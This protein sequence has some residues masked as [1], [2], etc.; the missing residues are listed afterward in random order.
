MDWWARR[1]FDV[2]LAAKAYLRKSRK[3]KRPFVPIQL[4]YEHWAVYCK[5]VKQSNIQPEKPYKQIFHTHTT[6][7]WNSHHCIPVPSQSN[8]HREANRLARKKLT[9][10]KRWFVA[11]FCTSCIGVGRTLK[12][13]KFQNYAK[14]PC[15]GHEEERSNHI[16]L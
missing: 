10:A 8:I 2:D 5:Q 7:Y 11:K 15:C 12:Y 13:R 9:L 14:C 1:N 3:E 6:N 4:K 16:L